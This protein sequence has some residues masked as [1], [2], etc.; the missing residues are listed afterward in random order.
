MSKHREFTPRT[1][2]EPVAPKQMPPQATEAPIELTEDQRLVIEAEVQRRMKEERRKLQ[3]LGKLPPSDLPAQSEIDR[4]AI[5]RPVMSRDGWVL[6]K[7]K[8]K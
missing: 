5:H 8:A 7:E 3:E 1:P 4:T 6:P 2:G